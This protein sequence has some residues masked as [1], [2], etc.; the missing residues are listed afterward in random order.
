MPGV[1][2]SLYQTPEDSLLVAEIAAGLVSKT[3]WREYENKIYIN[4]FIIL[5]D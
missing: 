4:I 2:M 3:L 5:R 1:H